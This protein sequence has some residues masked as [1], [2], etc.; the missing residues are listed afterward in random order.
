MNPVLLL[1]QPPPL[2]H[3]CVWHF[4]GGEIPAG[5]QDHLR[6]IH[7]T[8]EGGLKLNE[9]LGTT[10]SAP[11]PTTVISHIDEALTHPS[12]FATEL[13]AT[14]LA[15]LDDAQQN[16]DAARVEV[17]RAAEERVRGAADEFTKIMTSSQGENF[18]YIHE[19]WPPLHVEEID[20]TTYRPA[21]VHGDPP[22]ITRVWTVDRKGRDDARVIIFRRPNEG[23]E[24][25]ECLEV[26]EIRRATTKKEWEVSAHSDTLAA[27]EAIDRLKRDLVV[28]ALS[29]RPSTTS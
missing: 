9:D 2:C 27:L 11:A 23:G 26:L 4:F 21:A 19:K 22:E 14:V 28:Y 29:G 20:P 12:L 25:C 8:F 3:D 16:V 5:V 24:G 13:H 10:L 7:E 15:E 1:M 6:Q 18:V 17:Q